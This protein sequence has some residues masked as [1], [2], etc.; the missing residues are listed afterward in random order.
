M[1]VDA[2][3]DAGDEATDGPGQQLG[4]DDVDPHRP[5]DDLVVATRP[6]G[7]PEA[8]LLEPPDE[9]DRR[10]QHREHH[11]P[12]RHQRDADEADGAAQVVRVEPYRD[13]HLADRE[14]ADRQVEAAQSQAQ[15]AEVEGPRHQPDEPRQGQGK[16]ERH[17]ELHGQDGRAVGS[18]AEKSGMTE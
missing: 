8:R 18:H 12:G 5:R 10:Q 4:A 13:Q 14:G 11:G 7:D 1:G 9:V 2:A 17:P 6:E 3:C 16:P 15:Q